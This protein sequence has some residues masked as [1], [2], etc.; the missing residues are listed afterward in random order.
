MTSIFFLANK[1]QNFVEEPCVEFRRS[2][3]Y[4]GF[5]KTLVDPHQMHELFKELTSRDVLRDVELSV[6]RHTELLRVSIFP[7]PVGV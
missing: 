2:Y 7:R 5:H 6:V 3:F 1:F 4:D